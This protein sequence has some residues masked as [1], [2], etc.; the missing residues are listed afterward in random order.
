[1]T[2]S[3]LKTQLQIITGTSIA[4][5]I[6]DW[7]EYLLVTRVISYP[8]VLWEIGGA[9]FKK[10]IRTI[11]TQPV[12][13]LSLKVFAMQLYD[14]NSQ[15]KITVWD[16]I[17]GYLDV[18]LNKVHANSK[19]EIE[20]INEVQGTYYGLGAKDLER[21]IGLSYDITLKIYC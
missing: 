12:K 21:E 16:Q 4:E 17:E 20:N 10:D 5:V 11:P 7:N 8:A 3:E 14:S 6:F 9:K 2:L 13:R 1:M 18:Y 15:D 19:I